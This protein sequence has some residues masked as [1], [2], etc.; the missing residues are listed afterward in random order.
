MT[1]TKSKKSN[2]GWI[3]FIIFVVGALIIIADTNPDQDST[4]ISQ[5]QQGYLIDSSSIDSQKEIPAATNKNS[6]DAEIN[7]EISND[8][9]GRLELQESGQVVSLRQ[10]T[11][12]L[13]IGFDNI[14]SQIAY[15]V[16]ILTGHY[17]GQ[18]FWIAQEF[19]SKTE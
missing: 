13:V 3:L 7:A 10:K 6:Y 5:G 17:T 8:T 15:Q 11:K 14:D 4:T 1:E 16:R 18:T 19:I 2:I 12:V 9:T